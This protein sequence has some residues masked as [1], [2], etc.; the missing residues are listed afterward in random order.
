MDLK[1]LL[2][3]MEVLAKVER[4]EQPIDPGTLGSLRA[5]AFCARTALKAQ[6]AGL[7]VEAPR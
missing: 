5:D 4:L 7:E 2:D 3:A 1:Y 6:L